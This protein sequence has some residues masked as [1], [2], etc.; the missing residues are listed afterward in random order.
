MKKK[1]KI[2]IVALIIGVI[3]YLGY[4]IVK[5]INY[6]T[7]VAARI[8]SIPPFS[9]L[10][11]ENKEFTENNLPKNKIKL[12]VYFNS[13][14]EYCQSESTQISENIEQF[15]DTQLIFVSF[16][17]LANI[18]KFASDFNL[19]DKE[20]VIFLQDKKLEFAKIFD[21]KSIPFMLLYSKEGQLIQKFKGATKIDNI[22]KHLN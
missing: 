5:K 4:N 22:I 8:K 20:N 3:G 9:F 10:T 15:K 17:L 16:E 13:E 11:L 18:K 21:A 14:C 19:L 6:K 1:L 7:E 2:A 12:F